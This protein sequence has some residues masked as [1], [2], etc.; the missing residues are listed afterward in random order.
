MLEIYNCLQNSLNSIHNK[1]VRIV[2]RD[3]NAK[4]GGVK[5]PTTCLSKTTEDKTW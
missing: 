1:D 5:L 3:L 4:L 2:A